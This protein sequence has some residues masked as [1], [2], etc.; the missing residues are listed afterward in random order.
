MIYQAFS[1]VKT[2][3]AILTTAIQISRDTKNCFIECTGTDLTKAKVVLNTIVAMFS[4]YCRNPFEVEPVIIDYGSEK[5]LLPDLSEREVMPSDS[6]V[7]TRCSLF[8]FNIPPQA[9]ASIKDVRTI[10]GVEL[11]AKTIC[12]L[13][14]KMQLAA[15]VRPG[16]AE[17]AVKVG[18]E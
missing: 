3:W 17:V 18:L 2:S 6:A 12:K 9:S 5:Q 1:L 15:T 4:E 8:S 16:G 13:C 14:T 11:D 7:C 10:V